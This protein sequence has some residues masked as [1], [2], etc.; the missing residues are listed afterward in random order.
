MGKIPGLAVIVTVFAVLCSAAGGEKLAYNLVQKQF[1]VSPGS[2]RGGVHWPGEASHV[3]VFTV[4]PDSM[5][6]KKDYN[7]P[8]MLGVVKEALAG[9]MWHALLAK[10]DTAMSWE[11]SNIK[12][13][14]VLKSPS[15]FDRLTQ[16]T[17][18]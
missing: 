6:P 9:L 16:P 8:E 10:T 14:E 4:E 15:L 1:K 13:P 2:S 12:L 3:F 5:N 7:A 11:E 17:E 18:E